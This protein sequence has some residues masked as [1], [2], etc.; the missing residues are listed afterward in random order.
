MLLF[1]PVFIKYTQ[2]FPLCNIFLS[3]TEIFPKSSNFYINRY[4]T[5]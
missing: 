3:H 5:R 2:Y 4:D 1:I